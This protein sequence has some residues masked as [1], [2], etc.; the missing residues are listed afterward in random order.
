[1]R[2]TP[3]IV[4]GGLLLLGL[5]GPAFAQDASVPD[6]SLG[7]KLTATFDF[8]NRWVQDIAGSTDTYRS[9]V[10]LGE[11][12]KLFGAKV[13]YRNPAGR[14]ADRIDITANSWGGD[15]YNSGRLEAERSGAYSLRM[16][17][18]NVVYFNSLPTFANPLLGE[19]VLFS[20]RSFDMQRRQFDATLRVKP[21]A[22]ITPFFV[23]SHAAGFGRGVTTFVSDGNEFPV[24]TDLDDLLHTVRGGAEIEFSKLSLT[25][26]QG[27]TV[28]NDQ[29]EIFFGAGGNRGNRR[30]TL[31]GRQ[32]VLD[33]L[34]QSYDASGNGVFNR[35]VVQ[36]HPWERLSFSGQFLYSQPSI[37]VN[38]QE[39]A[40]GDLFALRALAPFTT[41]VGSSPAEANRP[42]SSG[43]WGTEVRPIGRLRV[44]QS[45]YTDRFHISAGAFSSQMRDTSREGETELQTFDLL[46][47]NYN[48]H[49]LDV[50]YDVGDRVTLRGGH[51]YV[52]GDAQVREPTLQ[53]RADRGAN[54]KIR[55]HVGL[56]GGVI[57][58]R[59][60][61][62]ITMDFE[63]F[64]GDQTFFRTGLMDYQKGKVRARYRV[65][66][67]LTFSGS[68]SILDN[69]NSDPEVRFEMQSRQSSFSAY[70]TPGGNRRFSLLADY[71]RSTLHSSIPIVVGP[72]LERRLASYRD[73]GHN[74]G[75]YGEIN[76]A[77]NVSLSLGGSLSV[78][79][80]S[81]PT[82]YYQP[83]AR[84]EVPL[85]GRVSWTAEWRWYGFTERRFAYENFRTHIIATGLQLHL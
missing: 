78:N 4:A 69:Q 11:G 45:W 44:V 34:R 47:L 24:Q 9:L 59:P 23:Y 55:R 73:N 31:F 49:Q 60:G 43:S 53:L 57:R 83:Q 25:L 5:C 30:T 56:A 63:A 33:S 13:A 74:A 20:Q 37:E 29:Q 21:Q 70:W 72:F 22:R 2:A 82:R 68:F 65:K 7:E 1:M 10:D 48:Q 27:G 52:W 3:N 54:G 84:V 71:T 58:A 42:H 26:E 77:R 61:L 38:Y 80:G 79:S 17:Y 51:R 67:S 15:P 50:I 32:L 28:Y 39:E 62:S 64:P 19:G 46:V 12:P 14:L 16:D 81:R 75:A 40:A 85:A 41:Q 18:R 35:A 36:G 66:P 8:G 76:L 6:P